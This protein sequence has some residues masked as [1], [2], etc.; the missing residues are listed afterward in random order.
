MCLL[1]YLLLFDLL[2]TTALHYFF[3]TKPKA[4]NSSICIKWNIFCISRSKSLL[5]E[6]V[7]F[8]KSKQWKRRRNTLCLIK[9]ICCCRWGLMRIIIHLNM[10]NILQ[11]LLKLLSTFIEAFGKSP[12]IKVIFA[13]THVW[14]KI[15]N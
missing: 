12:D 5:K 13:S 15:F 4:S 7:L 11:L 14:K 10:N 3:W 6:K 1:K 9:Q 8:L 2:T